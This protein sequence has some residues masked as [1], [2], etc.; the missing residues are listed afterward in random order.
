[1]EETKLTKEMIQT[2]KELLSKQ[3]CPECGHR[4]E[5]CDEIDCLERA[6][7]AGWVGSGFV[8]KHKYCALHARKLRGYGKTK[9]TS[10]LDG[11]PMFG[12]GER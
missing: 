1:M 4:M 12:G 3:E 7:Y 10:G 9:E 8:V 6:E 2:L 11:L 5:L